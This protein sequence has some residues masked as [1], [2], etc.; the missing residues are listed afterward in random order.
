MMLFINTEMGRREFPR[1]TKGMYKEK[2]PIWV[3]ISNFFKSFGI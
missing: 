1:K 3:E 2:K